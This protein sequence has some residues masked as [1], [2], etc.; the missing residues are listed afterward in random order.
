MSISSPVWSPDGRRIALVA[1]PL[2]ADPGWGT[3]IFVVNRDGSHMIQF[4]E[5]NPFEVGCSS[6][7][8]SPDGLYLAYRC[9]SLMQVG[10][11]LKQSDGGEGRSIDLGQ[12]TRVMWLP[13]GE[14][15]A[16]PGGM[17]RLAAF[18]A[19]F[20]LAGDEFVEP[21]PC[22]DQDLETLGVSLAYP[23]ELDWSP[24]E[25][26]RFI[27]ETEDRIQLVDLNAYGLTTYQSEVGRLIGQSSWSEDGRR[28]VFTAEGA[29][30][31]DLFAWVLETKEVIRLTV[32]PAADYMPA[33]QP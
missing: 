17:C 23:G 32:E 3:N 6:P 2:D 27:A 31:M 1:A 16:A 14:I 5:A 30:G 7:A 20:L 26:G 19:R 4:T 11:V 18:E 12:V 8:W 10:I 21:W 29:E 33:W 24:I 13:S 28:F 25:D 22:L 9:R 15:L